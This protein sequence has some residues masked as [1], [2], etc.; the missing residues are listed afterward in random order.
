[1]TD[2]LARDLQVVGP[3]S[4]TIYAAI[5]REDTNWIVILKDVGPDVS[6]QTAREGERSPP[7]D[8]HEREL[9]R[10]WLKASYRAVDENRS[11][12]GAPF[13]KLAQSS[14]EPVKPGEVYEYKIQILATANSFKA[15][16][17]ICLDI[18]SMDV[19]TGTGAMT[20]VEY[21]PYHICRSETVTHQVYHDAQRPSHL[22]LPVIS[23]RQ[24][25]GS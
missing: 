11:R 23:N 8:L 2:P 3:I 21:I 14:I 17:R 6:V 20:N 16:H 7:A 19:P 4:L 15:G 9:T 1:M 24:P 18:T 12:P 10:G 22:L 13:H 25:S 5:D